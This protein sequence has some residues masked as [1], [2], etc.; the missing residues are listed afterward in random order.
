MEKNNGRDTYKSGETDM[1]VNCSYEKRCTQ[2]D[3]N[4]A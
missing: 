1:Q 3:Q 2:G 4:F